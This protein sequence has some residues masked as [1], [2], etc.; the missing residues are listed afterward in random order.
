MTATQRILHRARRRMVSQSFFTALGWGLLVA[1]AVGAAGLVGMQVAGR[2]LP[3]WVLAVPA[4]AAVVVAV[5][6]A[7]LRRPDEAAVAVAI[8]QRLKLKDRLGTSLYA[9]T[10]EQ[11][12][13]TRSVIDDAEHA[14]AGLRVNEAFPLWP[15]GGAAS[16]V[17]GAVAVSVALLAALALDPAGLYDRALDRMAQ[18][19]AE[20][21]RA[22]QIE[23]AL[24]AAAKDTEGFA[25]DPEQRR[26][27]AAALDPADLN[28]QLE[29]MLTRRDLGNPEDRREAAAEVSDLQER[30]AQTVERKQ[31]AA[32]AMQSA[33]SRLDPG[34]RGPADRFADALRRGD[35]SAA[36]EEL[37]KLADELESGDLAENQKQQLGEQ[38][39]TLAR[40]LQQIAAERRQLGEQA[41]AQAEQAMRDAGLSPEQVD[42]LAEQG[43]S[44][45]AVQQALEQALQQAQG[46]SPEQAQQA[47]E[48]MQ[49]QMQQAMRQAQDGQQAG[50]MSEQLARQMSQMSKAVQEQSLENSQLAESL[51]QLQQKL[52]EGAGQQGELQNMQDANARLQQALQK[53]AGN[54]QQPGQGGMASGG[55]SGGGGGG[56]GPGEGDGSGG[57]PIGEERAALG[58][59]SHA[60][61]DI[62]EGRGG[63]VISS[64]TRDG[65]MSRGEATVTFDQAVTD[66]RADAER[67][68]TEDRT[69]RRYHKAIREYFG[70]LPA[71][72][73]AE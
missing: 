46:M 7:L 17:W 3:L 48:Q 59:A 34:E 29:A 56:V 54:G 38:L 33:M 31:R 6:V 28:E 22:E 64:W 62:Q 60:S 16:K 67:A 42:Q 25:E 50:E 43:F 49:Q 15:R 65:Q 4:A 41:Q 69:P 27:D 52:G 44:P 57:N 24:A 68:V 32:E 14:A 23:Q 18:A 45:E 55:G 47:A 63:R 36:Q 30:F 51:Q 53:L 37:G 11:S 39:D 13:L 35:F 12:P 2:V 9:A 20:R 5:L 21:E 40:Q 8:D 58:T 71:E 19:Q 10:L 70:N 61:G 66:A 72:P 73:T 26:D 1:A